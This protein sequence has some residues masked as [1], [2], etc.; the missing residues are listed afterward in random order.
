MYLIANS[1]V[2]FR[3]PCNLI[4]F[5][6]SD[7]CRL[8]VKPRLD[9]STVQPLMRSG[10]G[11]LGHRLRLLGLSENRDQPFSIELI[12]ISNRILLR[13]GIFS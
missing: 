12:R 2:L 10:M 3:W 5:S 13:F 7:G 1:G 4:T 9:S 11:H 6:I 8:A